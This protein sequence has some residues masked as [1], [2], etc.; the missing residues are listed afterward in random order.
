M[1][2]A[3]SFLAYADGEVEGI[4]IYQNA[5]SLGIGESYTLSAEV[6]GTTDDKSVNWSITGNKS[7]ETTIASDGTLSIALSETNNVITVRATANADESAYAE[8]EVRILQY[9]AVVTG[10]EFPKVPE[11]I[12]QTESFKFFANVLGTQSF[13]HCIWK[14][15]GNESPD[16][17]LDEY[18]NLYVARDETADTLTVRA[19]SEFDP[20]KYAEANVA[21]LPFDEIS[22]FEVTV[23]YDNILLSSD[24]TEGDVNTMLEENYE[25]TVDGSKGFE[26][27][28]MYLLASFNGIGNGTNQVSVDKN[29]YYTF[30]CELKPG[31]GWPD[32]VI[33]DAVDAHV[34]VGELEGFKVVING[35]EA[36]DAIVNYNAFWNGVRVYIPVGKATVHD[37][38]DF[39]DVRSSDWYY[40]AARYCS[41]NGFISGYKDGKFGPADTLQRQDFVVILARIAGADIS[42]FETC[43]LPDVNMNSYYGKAVAWAV[44]KGIIS[45]YQNGKFGVGD[46]I[47]REQVVTIF[48]RF[49]NTPEVTDADKTL[50]PFAD[51][52]RISPFAKDAMVW[53]IQNGVISGKKPDTLAPTATASRAEIAA[54]VMRMDKADMFNLF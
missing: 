22:A 14:L 26:S 28:L 21:V 6:Y 46:K 17:T 41:G 2:S 47:T 29:Y 49:M 32:S 44:D 20:T 5:L 10:V 4:K 54:I 53:A 48:Y 50:E 36:T 7:A 11:S 9:A 1:L 51:A 35:M 12:R 8:L 15:T 34:S 13:R 19:T 33:T 45:G 27:Y 3:F 40:E 25:I 30:Y 18:G 39:P 43:K 23:N 52:D 38:I 16:T 24:H 31:Y 42:G 37:P